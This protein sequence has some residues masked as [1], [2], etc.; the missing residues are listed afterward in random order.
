MSVRALIAVQV[1]EFVSFSTYLNFHPFT[2]GGKQLTAYNCTINI[3]CLISL[4]AAVANLHTSIIHWSV[5]RDH[6][7][8]VN[9]YVHTP[10]N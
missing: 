7:P 2:T 6:P 9:V 10:S 5:L 8:E 3:T 1:T 4:N